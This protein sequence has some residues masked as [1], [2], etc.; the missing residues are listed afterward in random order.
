MP[1]KGWRKP[2]PEPEV[3]DDAESIDADLHGLPEIPRSDFLK[4]EAEILSDKFGHD[5][6]AWNDESGWAW[7]KCSRCGGVISV[8]EAPAGKGLPVQPDVRF[9]RACV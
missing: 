6:D 9:N 8:A 5:L 7:A 3:D 4:T 1:P 2:K